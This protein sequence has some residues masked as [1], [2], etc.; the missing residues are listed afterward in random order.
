MNLI[1]EK[2][3]D[4]NVK[5]TYIFIYQ[6]TY[7]SDPFMEIGIDDLANELKFTIFE[8]KKNITLNKND[9]IKIYEK[10]T[11]FYE[12]ELENAKYY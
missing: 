11:E 4:I 10:A 8:N 3:G 2:I 1:F 6:D 7:N 5:Y 9:W 12:K